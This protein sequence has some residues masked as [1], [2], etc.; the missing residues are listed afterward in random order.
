VADWAQALLT[1]WQAVR[2]C[3]STDW[4]TM[5]YMAATVPWK[6]SFSP[7]LAPFLPCLTFLLPPRRRKATATTPT[8]AS[9]F[10]RHFLIELDQSFRLRLL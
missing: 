6:R 10:G 2:R 7:A 9:P 8:I 3:V 5:F 1:T 4:A